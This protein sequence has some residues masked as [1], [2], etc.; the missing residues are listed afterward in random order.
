MAEIENRKSD[1]NTHIS[2]FRSQPVVL[3]SAT[4]MEKATFTFEPMKTNFAGENF[5]TV[6]RLSLSIYKRRIGRSFVVLVSQKITVVDSAIDALCLLPNYL[7]LDFFCFSPYI[8]LLCGRSME[9]LS[10][11]CRQFLLMKNFKV[12]MNRFYS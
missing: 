8:L 9:C 6:E 1:A 12:L 5:T 2:S 3:T 7:N 4:L 11:F 10:P